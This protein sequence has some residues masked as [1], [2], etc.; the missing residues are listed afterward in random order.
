M[1]VRGFLGDSK[2]AEERHT[3]VHPLLGEEN[4]A[5]LPLLVGVIQ[6]LHSSSV[7]PAVLV[8]NILEY[9]DH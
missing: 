3:C 8:M 4:L 7:R 2:D 1:I 5:V 9:Q 6:V